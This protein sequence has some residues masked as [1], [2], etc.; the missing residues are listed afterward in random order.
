MS[1]V[2]T[3]HLHPIRHPGG[4]SVQRRTGFRNR[5]AAEHSGRFARRQS[6]AA[7]SYCGQIRHIPTGQRM[8]RSKRRYVPSISMWLFEM[9]RRDK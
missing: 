4:Q 5:P 1:R 2:W 8:L 7:P 6:C 9:L 3:K